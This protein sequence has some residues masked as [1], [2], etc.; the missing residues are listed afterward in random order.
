MYWYLREGEADG[1]RLAAGDPRFRRPG[2]SGPAAGE[3]IWRPLNNPPRIITSAF[4]DENPQR[5]R[6]APA[7][8]QLRPLPRR[9]LLRPAPLALDRAAGRLG[10]GLDPARRDPDRRRDPRQHRR[11]VGSGGARRA[12]VRRS[13]SAI[14]CTGRRTSPIRPRSPAVVATRLGNGGQAGTV[15]PEGRAQVHGRVQGRAPDQAADRRDPA[16]RCSRP[17][18]ASSPTSSPRRCPTTCPAIG[19]PSST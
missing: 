18:A 5:L 1:R 7:R 6:P 16:S 3:R 11:H 8:P 13:N 17:R 4:T 14:A 2:A 19:A 15:A 12:P 10:P 9:R